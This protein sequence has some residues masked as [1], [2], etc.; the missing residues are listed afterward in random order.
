VLAILLL[1]VGEV[2]SSERLIDE[3]WGERAQR[4]RPTPSRCMCPSSARRSATECSSPAAVVTFC[5]AIVAKWMSIV[6][7]R[8]WLPVAARCRQAIRGA[9]ASRCVRR[10]GCGA[11]R[12]GS[13]GSTIDQI[14][15]CVSAAIGLSGVAQETVQQVGVLLFTMD[16]FQQAAITAIFLSR[17]VA[18]DKYLTVDP[19]R[20]A[21]R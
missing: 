13:I 18:G 10:W 11:V 1:H 19:R 2:V 8:C 7:R 3:L 16:V 14:H 4:A 5:R 21:A 12:R 17:N 15:S 20:P 9:R 6:S